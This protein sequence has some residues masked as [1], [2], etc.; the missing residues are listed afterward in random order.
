MKNKIL[1]SCLFGFTLLIHFSP[2]SADE[3]LSFNP[4]QVAKEEVAA[5]KDYYD[6]DITGLTQHL[7]H[8]IIIEFRLNQMTA[9]KTVLPELLTAAT[10]FKNLPQNTSQET[11]NNIVLPHL[12][13]A[14]QGIRDGLQGSWDPHEAA[15]DELDWWVYRRQQKMANPEIVGQKITALYKLIYGQDPKNHF[16]RAGYLR[17]VAARYRDLSQ[18]AWHQIEETDWSIIENILELS[19]KEL[20]MGIQV[21]KERSTLHID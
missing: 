20:L 5:W 10:L 13:N 1:L 3:K 12:V 7:S 19:Y 18:N 15:K 17:A 14:Y 21:N 2:I 16:A 6:N 4:E 8:L 9:W 11:Y